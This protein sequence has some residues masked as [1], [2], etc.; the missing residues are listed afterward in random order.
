MGEVYVKGGRGEDRQALVAVHEWWCGSLF[1]HGGLGPSFTMCGVGHS[2]SFVGGAAGCLWFFM[3]GVSGH[4]SFFLGGG[5]GPLPPFMAGG[6]GPSFAVQGAGRSSF[7]V[8]GGA[9]VRG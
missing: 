6:G 5:A 3:G 8:G 4:S 2:S 1:V 7:F 9:I